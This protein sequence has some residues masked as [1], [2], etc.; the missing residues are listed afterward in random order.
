MIKMDFQLR[1][2]Q[3]NIKNNFNV[4]NIAKNAKVME[5]SLKDQGFDPSKYKTGVRVKNNY[6]EK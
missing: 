5:K 1:N 4:T 6:Y 3:L 2:L